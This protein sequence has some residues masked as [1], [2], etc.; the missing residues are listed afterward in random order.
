MKEVIYIGE[1]PQEKVVTFTEW[2]DKNWHIPDTKAGI[3][4]WHIQQLDKA[5]DQYTA[6]LTENKNDKPVEF[7]HIMMPD[8]WRAASM[9][10]YKFNKIVYLGKRDNADL[11]SA[12]YDGCDTIIYKGHLNSGKY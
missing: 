11:F 8:G 1:K 12:Y 9:E 7:T 5:V 6:Y 2:A 4:N 10:G 3:Q